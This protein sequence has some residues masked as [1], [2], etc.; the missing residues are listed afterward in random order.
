MRVLRGGI[1]YFAVLAAMVGVLPVVQSGAAAA[2]TAGMLISESARPDGFH[3]QP[4]GSVISYWTIDSSGTSRPASGALFVPAGE[5][6]A[7]GWPIVAFDHGTTGLGKG[8]GGKSDPATGPHTVYIDEED[9]LMRHLVSLG[10]AVAA[11]DYLG[12]GLYD[13][14]PH[15]YLGLDTEAA[16]TIDMVR[17][18][19]SARPELSRTWTVLGLSQ[20]GQA[21]LG[22]GWHQSRVAPDLDFRGTIAV[23][24]ESDIEKAL[25]LAGPGFPAIPGA[26]NLTGYF[27]DILAGLRA[28][29]PDLD[30]DGYLTPR[31]KAL[32]DEV[33]TLCQPA[34]DARVQGVG[35]GDLLSKPLSDTTIRAALES[36]M[37]I[38]ATGYNAPILLLLNTTD[39]E[40]PAPLHG[41]LVSR[42]AANGVD[43]QVVSGTGR[44]VQLNP[45]MWSAL[46]AFLNGIR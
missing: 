26:E 5:A 18:A 27:A 3:G 6:P 39:T 20:G 35:I 32:L 22:T 7:G 30:V 33:S 38:P 25:P 37:T 45:Q 2:E 8:C 43:F 13:T 17:A 29:R 28:A 42:F 31:G 12:L 4:G 1:G 44:H 46:D 23:D 9:A 40:V 19:R 36:Y 16:A 15:P 11:P 34:I 41:A 14:G 21:A 24:P 10:F